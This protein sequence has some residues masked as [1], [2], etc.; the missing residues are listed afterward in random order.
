MPREQADGRVGTC[1]FRNDGLLE[2]L[3]TYFEQLR[4]EPGSGKMP[5]TQRFFTVVNFEFP[6]HAALSWHLSA[7]EERQMKNTFGDEKRAE[8]LNGKMNELLQWW[9]A[10]VYEAPDEGKA[11]KARLAGFQR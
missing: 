10:D 3:S 8:E 9:K 7:E 2:L 4:G 11:V 6:G 1:S 5:H